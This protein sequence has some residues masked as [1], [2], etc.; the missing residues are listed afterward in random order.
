MFVAIHLAQA[1]VPAFNFIMCS[2]S[3]QKKCLE[4]RF[5]VR[6]L[7]V[8]FLLASYILVL[9]QPSGVSANWFS[10]TVL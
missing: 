6:A 3:W 5:G 7:G 2:L 4:K 10:N 1:Y 8:I 9:K